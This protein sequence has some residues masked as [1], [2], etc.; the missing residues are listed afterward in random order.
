L[1]QRIHIGCLCYRTI[2][3]TDWPMRLRKGSSS[4]ASFGQ[5]FTLSL[6]PI[7]KLRTGGAFPQ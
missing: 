2:E 7:V 3:A 6:E 4:F 5:D 1:L